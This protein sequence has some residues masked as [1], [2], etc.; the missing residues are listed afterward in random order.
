MGIFVFHN[1]RLFFHSTTEG[2]YTCLSIDD[3]NN[4]PNLIKEV[5]GN[6]HLYIDSSRFTLLPNVVFLASQAKD[7]FNLNFGSLELH[8]R[9]YFTIKSSF[10]LS[11]VFA[12]KKEV[13]DFRTLLPRTSFIEHFNTIILKY[14][15]V[16]IPSFEPFLVVTPISVYFALKGEMK[17]QQLSVS[18]FE[19]EIDVIYFFMAH[20]TSLEIKSIDAFHIS[21]LND[22]PNFNLSSFE[23]QIKSI[24]LFKDTTMFNVDSA[25]LFLVK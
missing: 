3:T 12:I 17:L 23:K 1:S 14:L 13:D 8:E 10:E 18:D 11:N 20:L 22:V 15:K 5:E 2:N 4:L 6:H 24:T 9:I 21:I 16:S 25:H 19:N 7:Y